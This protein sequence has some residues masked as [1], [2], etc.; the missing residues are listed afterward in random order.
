MINQLKNF[1]LFIAFLLI[2]TASHAGI[3]EV[4]DYNLVTANPHITTL[5]FESGSTGFSTPPDI[6]IPYADGGVAQ[7]YGAGTLNYF[8]HNNIP[9]DK[10]GLQ[11][12]GNSS[13][14]PRHTDI[15]ANFNTPVN[16][17]GAWLMWAGNQP[18]RNIEFSIFGTNQEL[19]YSKTLA[20]PQYF[21]QLYFFGVSSTEQIGR[22]VWHSVEDSFFDLDNLSYGAAPSQ[23][24][25]EPSTLPLMSLAAL[26]A[27]LNAKRR[28]KMR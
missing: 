15:F 14:F 10:F 19:L 6:D 18:V 5:G 4:T 8:A 13:T 7:W 2:G 20:A 12:L 23:P 26:A 28:R 24:I 3:V 17:V 16:F 27:F 22:V 11:Y 9:A 1:I 25:S 21:D